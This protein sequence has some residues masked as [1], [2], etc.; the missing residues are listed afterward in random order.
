MEERI[1]DVYSWKIQLFELNKRVRDRPGTTTS[2]RG[3]TWASRSFGM[4]VETR[5][6][7]YEQVLYLHLGEGEQGLIVMN[8]SHKQT[9]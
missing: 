9:R 3:L 4:L 7:E 6:N 1:R 2:P 5:V 8:E